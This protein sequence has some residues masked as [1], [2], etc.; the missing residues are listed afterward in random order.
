VFGLDEGG[1]GEQGAEQGDAEDVFHEVQGIVWVM[2]EVWR[3]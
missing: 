2:D 1:T 3:C